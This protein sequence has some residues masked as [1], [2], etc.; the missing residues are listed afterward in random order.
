MT[1]EQETAPRTRNRVAATK[2]TSEHPADAKEK[3]NP[4]TPWMK[5]D[6]L[7]LE[8]VDGEFE[9]RWC[10]KNDLQGIARREAQGFKRVT[11]SLGLR[12]KSLGTP[13]IQEGEKSETGV[14]EEGDLVL[15]CLPK[16]LA[17][18]RREAVAERNQEVM[19]G[20]AD[21]VK[22][23]LEKAGAPVH[24]KVEIKNVEV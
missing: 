9:F 16:D 10:S 24:G 8:D 6:L 21:E 5:G 2:R 20:T 17:E 15:M 19:G 3:K 14:I 4:F 1:D 11:A 13:R 22:G 18:M 12:V 7:K 23:Q